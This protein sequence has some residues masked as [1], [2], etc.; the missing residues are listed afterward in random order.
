MK[1]TGAQI[2]WEV[3]VSEG[4][5]VVFGYPGGAIMPAYDTILGY[6]IRHVLVRHEQGAAHMADGYARAS[7]KVG[8]AV[9]TSGPGATNLVTGIATAMLDSSP[10][11][12]ITGQVSSK[13]LGTDAFQETDITGVTLPI[14]KHNYLV[15]EVEDI[16]PAIREAFYIARSGRPGPVLV[17]ITKDAQ[18][19]SMD[20][21]PLKGEVRLPGYR[22]SYHAVQTDIEKAIELIDDAERPLILAGQGIVRAEATRELL[23]FVEKTGIPVASTLLG[24]GGFPATH[25][26]SLGMMG[27]HGEA[28][29]N[30][31]IQEADLLIALGMRFDDRV[32]GNLKTY[33]VKAKKIHVEID[34]SEIN[35]NVK[36]DVGLVG[37]VR[38]TLQS[39]IPGVKQ[40]HRGSWLERIGALKGDSAVRDIQQLPYNEKLYAA[41]VMHDL[42]RLTDGKA[43][44]VTDVGQHQM[45][46]AQYYKHDH[47]RKLITSGGLG[48]MGFALPAAIGARF[49]KPE[50]EVWVVVGDGGFQM[51]ACELSTCAQEGIK[52]HV[53]VINNGYLGMVR[54]WQEFFYNRRYSATPMRSPDFVK[55]AEAHGLTGIRVTKREE[56][57]DAVERARATPGTVVVDFRVEQEDSVYPMVPAGADLKDMI[58]RPSPIVETGEDP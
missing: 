24:L 3:L 34:R 20:Y 9:A 30:H 7:G 41:H 17:D 49:A 39:L 55:L 58:R 31:A 46:E 26:L 4:V 37:D 38:D 23:A 15:T 16:A 13:L 6:P 42:W 48:T 33:A 32:T 25:P 56:I 27:M 51:T 10:I 53:A 52:V 5:D 54:Q 45:W 47:P 28:W 18:Q 35:K 40:R 14:T 21:E 50:E 57:A 29:V 22:P 8:V 11:V 19:A 44:V 43:L 12:C 36:V 2:I 1:R